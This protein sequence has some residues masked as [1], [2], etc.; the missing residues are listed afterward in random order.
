MHQLTA[1]QL[2]DLIGQALIIAVTLCG[3][4]VEKFYP[5]YF[6][7]GGSNYE[8]ARVRIFCA[9]N[10]IMDTMVVV[11]ISLERTKMLVQ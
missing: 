9:I 4:E 6:D 3:E 5:D 1:I 8:M 7:D 10:I 2:E 11:H